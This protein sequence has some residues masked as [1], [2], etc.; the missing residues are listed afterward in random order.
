MTKLQ[1]TDIN[2]DPNLLIADTATLG[3]FILAGKS[4][5]TIANERSGN[6]LTF[7]VEVGK[8]RTKKGGY[9]KAHGKG[10]WFVSVF[11][12]NSWIYLGTIFRKAGGGWELR[13]TKRSTLGK[14][15]SLFRAF[16]WLADHCNVGKPLPSCVKAWRSTDCGRCG[17]ELISEHRLIGYGPHCCKAMGVDTKVLFKLDTDEKRLAYLREALYE[18]AQKNNPTLH[19]LGDMASSEVVGDYIR[20]HAA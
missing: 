13:A 10:P 8:E 5:F 12:R 16:S 11:D 7:K 18:H 17:K 4:T 15:S 14:G 1:I 20:A 6:R 9:R 3:M 19:L 2:V